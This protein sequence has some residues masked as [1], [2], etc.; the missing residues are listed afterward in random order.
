MN[1]DFDVNLKHSFPTIS[2]R[3]VDELIK[4]KLVNSESNRFYKHN[5]IGIWCGALSSNNSYIT[6]HGLITEDPSVIEF[7]QGELD[8]VK[9]LM[10]NHKLNLDI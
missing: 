1:N 10:N 5:Q 9:S 8:K 2:N 4:F 3:A 6:K 7:V